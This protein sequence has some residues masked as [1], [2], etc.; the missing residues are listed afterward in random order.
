ML[1]KRSANPI[2]KPKSA[3]PIPQMKLERSKAIM[4]GLFEGQRSDQPDREEQEDPQAAPNNHTRDK[5]REIAKP[6]KG[7]AISPRQ[8]NPARRKEDCG[9]VY[10]A[11]EKSGTPASPVCQMKK[12]GRQRGKSLAR[13]VIHAMS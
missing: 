1:P 7:A 10:S 4:L 13:T 6:P 2:K 12:R 5:S 3:P 8:E 11:A 9:Q